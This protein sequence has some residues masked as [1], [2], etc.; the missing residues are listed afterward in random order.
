MPRIVGWLRKSLEGICAVLVFVFL[1][2][3]IIQAIWNTWGNPTGFMQGVYI[4]CL[5]SYAVVKF[6]QLDDEFTKALVEGIGSWP[7]ILHLAKVVGVPIA[8]LAIGFVLFRGIWPDGIAFSL[9]G[10]NDSGP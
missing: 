10:A 4:F 8:I 9:S 3:L 5:F 2:G 7:R 6:I 1:G